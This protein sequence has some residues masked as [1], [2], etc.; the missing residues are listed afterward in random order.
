M[1]G[2]HL[3]LGSWEAG[4]GEE[5]LADTLAARGVR[6]PALLR[7]PGAVP[8]RAVSLSKPALLQQGGTDL[9]V[10]DAVACT[11]CR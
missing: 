11:V 5:V 2:C 7:A 9:G 4:L 6:Q 10:W 8:W 1:G 3:A